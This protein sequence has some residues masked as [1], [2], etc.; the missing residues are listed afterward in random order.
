MG[1]IAIVHEGEVY[2]CKYFFKEYM[3]DYGYKAVMEVYLVDSDFRYEKLIMLIDGDFVHAVDDSILKN[4]IS[5]KIQKMLYRFPYH[6][7]NME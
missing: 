7:R 2:L 4:V 5:E 3:C 6:L 1:D